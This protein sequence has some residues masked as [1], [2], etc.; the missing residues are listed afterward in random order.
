[1]VTRSK[2]GIFKPK[3]PSLLAYTTPKSVQGA[4]KDPNWKSAMEAEIQALD[5]NKTWDL[6]P[7]PPGME[8]IGC[9]WIF[10]I[11][12]NP[13]GSLNKFKV[14]LVAKGFHQRP[15]LNFSETFSPV[16]KPIT[17]RLI[18][19][20]AL[21][22]KWDIQQLDVNNAF[23][24]GDLTET[25]YMKQPPGFETSKGLVCRLRKALYGLKQAP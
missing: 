3:Q 16:I 6:V 18:L 13:D 17:V 1:M 9:K 20:L 19:T 5:S 24:N 8:P 10:R 4:L 14:R 23:L 12:Q 15:G 25:V 7:L 2:N 11:K 21:S 22:Y